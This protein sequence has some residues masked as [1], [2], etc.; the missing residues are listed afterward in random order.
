MEFYLDFNC[1]G[2]GASNYSISDKSRLFEAID[3]DNMTT[4]EK[5]FKFYAKNQKKLLQETDDN[6]RSLLHY[7]CEKGNISIVDFLADK[8]KANG[9]PLDT[10]DKSLSTPLDLACI[11]GY[12]HIDDQWTL[13]PD[14]IEVEPTKKAY[15]ASYSVS[16][17]YMIAKKLFETYYEGTKLRTVEIH[18]D[19]L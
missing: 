18:Y 17:R 4:F 16:F 1:I 12:N 8:Y 9:L 11:Y 15:K 6:G 10:L 2:R 7:A 13:V 19:R 14:N 5:I 3:D